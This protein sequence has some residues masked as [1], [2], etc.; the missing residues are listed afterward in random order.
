MHAAIIEQQ[1][2]SES[3]SITTAVG[4]TGEIRYGSYQQGTIHVPT[5]SSLTTLTWWT[6]PHQTDGAASHTRRE[7]GTYV[8]A[9]DNAGTPAAVTQTVAQTRTFPIPTELAGAAFIKAVG[10]AAGTIIVTKKS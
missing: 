4:T 5:G 6:A 8:P 9:Y 2:T 10:N 7:A 1:S 3:V